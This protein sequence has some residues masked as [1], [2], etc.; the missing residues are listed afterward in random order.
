M[1]DKTAY[2]VDKTASQ[3]ALK[4]HNADRVARI[5]IQDAAMTPDNYERLVGSVSKIIVN[6]AESNELL[7]EV[8]NFI[9]SDPNCGPC[10]LGLVVMIDEQL[11]KSIK[12]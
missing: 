1:V 5:I 3:I 12:Q 9:A 2:Q 4:K 7:L 10:G 8:R 6:H 11:N